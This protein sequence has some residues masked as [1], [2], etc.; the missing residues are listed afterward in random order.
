[1]FTDIQG[2]TCKWETFPDGM[3][4]VLALHDRVIRTE[5]E[6]CGGVVVKHT[7]D[8]FMAV[9]HHGGA[10]QCALGIQLAIRRQDWSAVNGLAVRV[11]INSGDAQQRGDDYFGNPVNRAM[12]LMSAAH[13]GQTVISASAAAA[14]AVPDGAA[15][16]DLGRHMLKDLQEPERIFA[17]AHPMLDGDHPPLATVS[18]QPQNLPVQPTPFVGRARELDELISLVSGVDARLVTVLGHGG[19]GKTRLALQAAAELVGAFSDGVWFVPLESVSTRAGMVAEIAGC[20]SVRFTERG[21]EEGQLV[22]AVKGMKALLVLD[23]FEHLTA[24]ATLVADL[25]AVSGGTRVIATS[26]NLLGIRSEALLDLSGMA[27]PDTLTRDIECFDAT[28]LFLDSARR[29]LPSFS[30]SP[31]DREAIFR[32]CLLLQGLPLAIEL[33]ASWV[34]TIS[35]TELLQELERDLGL[36]ESPASDAPTRQRS[37]QAVFDYSWSLLE[38]D[39]RNSLKGLSVFHGGFDRKAAEAV[40]FCGLRSLQRLSGT[41]LVRNRHGG[42]HMLHPLTRGF[43]RE[44]LSAEPGAEDRFLDRHSSHF[45]MAVAEHYARVHSE[46]QAEALDWIALEL[47]NLRA[48]AYHAFRNCRWKDAIALAQA[49]SVLYLLRSRF[50]EAVEFFGSLNELAD[51]RD[52]QPGWNDP[53]GVKNR[54]LL[55][56]RLGS[57]NL[58]TGNIRDASRLLEEAVSLLENCDDPAL[59]ALCL[60]GLGNASHLQGDLLKA[61]ERWSR[62]L[63]L[64]RRA[65]LGQSVT[66]L[67]CNISSVRKRRG[68]LAGARLLLHEAVE[69]NSATGNTF[70]DATLQTNIAEILVL[71]GDHDGA[72]KNHWKALE[73]RRKL[74]DLRGVSYSLERLSQLETRPDEALRLAVESLDFAE[75]SGGG[76]RAVYARAQLASALALAGEMEKAVENM[77]QAVREAGRYELPALT[78]RCAEVRTFINELSG[79][80]GSGPSG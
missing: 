7:G 61:D 63:V 70:L 50:S 73:M 39:D 62:A 1:M 69:L 6:R 2:S 46:H 3:G 13:G 66:S 42:G 18:S 65:G 49:V 15:L 36:L 57:F 40:A 51:S 64:S 71:E 52:R 48:A 5:I 11:G 19:S 32:I 44:M 76:N 78:L 80:G 41:S 37:L 28:R 75:K 74:G 68:D 60:A 45:G 17:L 58:V 10:I 20:L 55:L 56:E 30:P 4:E 12:R 25:L 8:G 26:R 43:A 14:E 77:E 24:C 23:N 59:E 16:K 53:E 47:P 31:A 29:V 34:R 79:A 21:N 33:A 38:E 9:F 27:L 54:A 67:L 35:C 22:S 72:R